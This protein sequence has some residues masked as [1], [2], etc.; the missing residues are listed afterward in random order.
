[1]TVALV[2]GSSVRSDGWAARA[3]AALARAWGH[4]GR[5][6]YLCDLALESPELH[7]AL[8]VTN[9]EGV[10]DVLLYG[11][12]PRHV[13]RRIDEN[14]YLASAGTVTAAPDAVRSSPRW[15]ALVDAFQEAGALL[16][17]Y[18]PAGVPGVEAVLARADAVVAL[19]GADEDLGLGEAR[20]RLVA[21]F[22]PPGAERVDEEPGHVREPEPSVASEVPPAEPERVAATRPGRGGW[23]CLRWAL[24]ILALVV[25]VLVLVATLGWVRL[26]GV[27]PR[28]ASATLVG[29][30]AT[31]QE[32]PPNVEVPVQAWSLALEAHLDGEVAAARVRELAA[33]FPDLLFWVAPVRVRDQ[34]FHRVLAGPATDAD[35]VERLRARLGGNPSWIPRRAGLAFRLGE[36]PEL[37]A[38]LT[39]TEVLAGIGIPTHVLA[40]PGPAGVAYHVFAGGYASADEASEL[41]DML[42]AQDL[43]G[44]PLTERRGLVPA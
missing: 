3:A 26:P 22:G 6:T 7:E 9:Q 23:G 32:A 24:M 14:L 15:D 13:A 17:L 30:V 1:V 11:A 20:A 43:T 19:G 37:E 40:V 5:R 34:R 28:S 41:A 16:L 18:V 27:G 44:A 10:S 29:S 39:W 35:E 2:A 25:L 36:L 21:A 4:E 12:S 33:R 31:A 42:R 8:D 38:A